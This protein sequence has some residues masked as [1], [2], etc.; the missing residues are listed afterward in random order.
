MSAFS[1]FGNKKKRGASRTPT[2][3]AYYER[4][5]RR[6]KVG[7]F[8]VIILLV[9]FCLAGYTFYPDE[10]TVEN[11]RYL[12]KF[13]S[14]EQTETADIGSVISFDTDASNRYAIVRGDIAILSKTALTVFDTSGQRLQKVTVKS[15]CPLLITAG[16][17]ML[18]CDLGGTKISVYNSF[19]KV[20][21]EDFGYP[22]LGVT[23]AD[24]GTYAVLSSAKNY[25]SAIFVYDSNY[26]QIFAHYYSSDYATAAVLNGDGNR[27]LALSHV[28]DGG[29]YVGTMAL[30]DTRA[31]EPIVSYS[32]PDELPLSCSFAPD[33]GYALLTDKALRFYSADNQLLGN[34]AT[35][36]ARLLGCV[37]GES[38]AALTYST[39]GLA[40][41]K[42]LIVYDRLGN[43]V[44]VQ[45]L[46]SAPDDIIIND[47]KLYV[48]TLGTLTVTDLEGKADPISADVDG[49][50][51]DII[52][53][54]GRLLVFTNSSVTVYA[55]DTLSKTE[56]EEP[57][58]ESSEVDE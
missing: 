54:D 20:Y 24:N 57:E 55:A 56:M 15:D 52:L 38:Y 58:T 34:A 28:T 36:T 45:T 32:Y 19:S 3:E 44:C 7:M 26:R 51:R 13:I 21:T 31:E 50:S 2:A 12:L 48:L 10:L 42:Q 27:L 11:F 8:S 46:K 49:D 41:A 35:D 43:A 33:G 5:A 17:N 14:V 30:Y 18:V 1:I 4:L 40:E 53:Y 25:R 22:I 37:Y 16:K 9:T 23:A 39:D 6:A 29:E 47:G